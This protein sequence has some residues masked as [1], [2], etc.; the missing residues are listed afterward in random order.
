MEAIRTNGF[1][2]V[3]V[4]K[5]QSCGDV[6]MATENINGKQYE[7]YLGYCGYTSFYAVEKK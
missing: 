3:R 5:C 7:I 2:V 4:R 6:L 1:N